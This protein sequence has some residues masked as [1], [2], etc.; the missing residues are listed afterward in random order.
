MSQQ[1]NAAIARRMNDAYNAQDWD[2]AANLAASNTEFVNVATAEK[3]HGQ[4]GVRQFLKGWATAFPGSRVE[5]TSVIAD[6]RAAVME[7][8]G[9]GTHQGPLKGPAGEIAPT[10]RSVEVH[11]CEVL[12]IEQDKVV[13]GRLYFDSA[14]M[15]QQLGLMPASAGATA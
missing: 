1:D 10:G 6:E 3:F 11:F 7:F 4:D 12:E 15:L 14:T 2:A 5:T 8:V 9:R 13:R